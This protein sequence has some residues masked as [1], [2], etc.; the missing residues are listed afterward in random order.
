MMDMVAE[1]RKREIH[2]WSQT[3]IYNELAR[4][5]LQFN[6]HMFL[7]EARMTKTGENDQR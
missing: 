3:P 4:K 5:L 7:D 1:L 2:T 6:E